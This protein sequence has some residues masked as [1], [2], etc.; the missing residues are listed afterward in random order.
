MSN[1]RLAYKDMNPIEYNI[2]SIG[3]FV[4]IIVASIFMEEIGLV[5]TL[6]SAASSTCLTFLFPG[7]FYLIA[8]KKYSTGLFYWDKADAT[9]KR[10]ALFFVFMGVIMYAI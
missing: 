2:L 9:I 10:L 8:L 7:F 4:I 6:L 1:S 3:S 5:F